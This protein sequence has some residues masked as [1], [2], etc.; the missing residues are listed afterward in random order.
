MVVS[1]RTRPQPA[2]PAL[3]LR[4]HGIGKSLVGFQLFSL[5]IVYHKR[6]R[7]RPAALPELWAGRAC[8]R[9]G[10]DRRA[11]T[12]LGS[13]KKLEARKMLIEAA[14]SQKSAARFVRQPARYKTL[15]L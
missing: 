1:R 6:R 15:V 9:P 14:D 10:I 11:W 3:N 4:F 5:L 13:R 12:M 7:G 8:T 2:R